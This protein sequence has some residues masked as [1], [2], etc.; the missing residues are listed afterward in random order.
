MTTSQRDTAMNGQDLESL[1]P[2]LNKNYKHLT[3]ED[4]SHFLEH[5]WI[6]VQNSMNKEYVDKWLDD[7][8]VRLG[9]DEHDKTTWT[10]E[11]QHLPRHRE[12]PAEEFCP[13]AYAK[14]VELCG[15]GIN[16]ETDRVDEQRETWYGDAFIVNL[17][18]KEKA[19]PEYVEVPPNEKSGWHIDDD[20]FRMFLDSQYVALTIILCFADIPEGGGGTM[21]AEDTM[22]HVCQWLYDHREGLDPPLPYRET[23]CARAT[24]GKR[25][26]K[27][28]AKKGDIIITHGRLPHTVGINRRHYAR[29]IANP[30][31]SLKEPMN[32]DRPDG[33]YSLV[34]QKILKSLGRTSVPDFKPLRPRKLY[35]PYRQDAKRPKA[36]EEVSRMEAAAVAKGLPKESVGS[37]YQKQGTPEFAEFERR[38]G[39][40]LT[41]RPEEDGTPREAGP[42]SELNRPEEL[43]MRAGVA[44]A[45][46]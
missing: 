10:T 6:N 16:V 44:I 13:L 28:T 2:N 23:V 39:F 1:Y 4:V 11:Y 22:P 19:S 18:T 12:V 24:E 30:H 27:L 15:G 40:D 20:F 25:F 7:L 33:N 3:P 43:P 14:M 34:E 29:V 26:T 41:L 45:A 42:K 31:I 35:Y 9:M 36:A 5:G 32:F 38:N 21:L 37:Y 46:V 17:G 8:W